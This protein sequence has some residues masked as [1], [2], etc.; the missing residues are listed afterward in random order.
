MGS[1]DMKQGCCGTDPEDGPISEALDHR[2]DDIESGKLKTVTYAGA[3]EYLR[4]LDSV[5]GE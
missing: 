4:H 1:A 5:L 3:D 2:I